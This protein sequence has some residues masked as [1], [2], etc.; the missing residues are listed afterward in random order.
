MELGVGCSVRGGRETIELWGRSSVVWW[1]HFNSIKEGQGLMDNGWF[2]DY[3]NRLV[4]DVSSTLFWWDVWLGR[5]PLSD[6]FNQFYDLSPT[7]VVTVADM[8]SSG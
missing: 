2:R 7:K 8:H 4:G 5:V 1:R 6:R 3:I